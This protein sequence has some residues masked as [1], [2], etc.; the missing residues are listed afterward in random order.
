MFLSLRQ[1][2]RCTASSAVLQT[3]RS[4]I[5]LRPSSYRIF[6][7]RATG[8]LTKSEAGGA[9]MVRNLRHLALALAVCG[10]SACSDAP[11]SAALDV[12]VK[13][14][15]P[16]Y[17]PTN[18]RPAA[19]DTVSKSEL[20]GGG[21]ASSQGGAGANRPCKPS[22]PAIRT[23]PGGGIPITAPELNCTSIPSL[24]PAPK[25]TPMPIPAPAPATAPALLPR[26]A[27]V[28]SPGPG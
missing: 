8:G 9:T 14:S 13:T 28:P 15:E 26:P 1:P 23:G 4:C 12:P 16:T 6:E 19:I 11:E 24:P 25:F 10:L 21:S 2:R 7:H 3:E 18:S 17:T 20:G 5:N 22:A 27:P